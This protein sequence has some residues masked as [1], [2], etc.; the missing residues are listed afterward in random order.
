MAAVRSE[1]L[2][3]SDPFR[4]FVGRKVLVEE[5][6]HVVEGYEV[7]GRDLRFRLRR[8]PSGQEVRVS[9]LELLEL[10]ERQGV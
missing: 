7:H 3:H 4:C 5:R 6:P 8:L 9:V 1:P 2:R 10:M